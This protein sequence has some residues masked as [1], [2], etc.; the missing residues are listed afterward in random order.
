MENLHYTGVNLSKPVPTERHNPTN[1]VTVS[2]A[3]IRCTELGLSRTPKTI[4]KWAA[5]SHSSPENA[6]ISVRRE[7]TGNGFRWSIELSSLDR[8]IEEEL[9]FE[10][11]KRGAQ[12]GTS[13][14]VSEPVP[15]EETFENQSEPKQTLSEPARTG[16][17]GHAPNAAVETELRAQLEQ[18][19]AEVEFLRG[20]LIHRR[21][22]DEALGSVIE[23]F[24]LNS[25]V[26]QARMLDVQSDTKRASWE[27]SPRHDIVHNGE[28]ED[29][30]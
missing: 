17:E 22:T 16:L 9:E 1:W 28:E 11:R 15:R 5:R 20:E 2:E 4:R 21:K 19:Q 12:A 18:T 6:D 25:E 27:A 24:R 10:A 26:N 29:A 8:K 23:A 14:E 13:A 30:A 7:D 3:T